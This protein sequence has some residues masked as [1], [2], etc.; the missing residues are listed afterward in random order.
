MVKVTPLK[1][2]TRFMS[3]VIPVFVILYFDNLHANDNVISDL[4]PVMLTPGVITR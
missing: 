4:N 2:K 3:T 1:V